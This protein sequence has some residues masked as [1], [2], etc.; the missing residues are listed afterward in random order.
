MCLF[1]F[2][3]KANKKKGEREGGGKEKRK[4]HIDGFLNFSLVS[5]SVRLSGVNVSFRHLFFT[6]S[7]NT[8]SNT[9]VQI[10]SQFNHV[11]SKQ[12]K[13]E[14]KKKGRKKNYNNT[15]CQ[16]DEG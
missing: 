6:H 11:A 1:A 3:P 12:S 9:K 2:S 15:K 14:R 7:R 10:P 8:N 13:E 5:P 4:K 16:T